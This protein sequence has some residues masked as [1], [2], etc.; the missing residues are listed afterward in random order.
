VFHCLN[1][2]LKHRSPVDIDFAA[3]EEGR[4]VYR[5][6]VADVRELVGPRKTND[7]RAISA[8]VDALKNDPR[9]AKIELSLDRRSLDWAFVDEPDRLLNAQPYLSLDLGIIASL[10]TTLEVYLYELCRALDGMEFPE[11][12]LLVSDL[13]WIHGKTPT[14]WPQLKPAFLRAAS[15]ISAVLSVKILLQIEWHDDRSRPS[16]IRFRPAGS[17]SEWS[18]PDVYKALPST[19]QILVT[20]SEVLPLTAERIAKITR[21]YVAKRSQGPRR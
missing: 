6:P 2:L 10:G 18:P 8:A 15:R 21:A 3:V 11:R 17:R 19:K 5:A 16:R 13:C 14:T 20:P 1:Y 12:A 4:L 7:T 9:L